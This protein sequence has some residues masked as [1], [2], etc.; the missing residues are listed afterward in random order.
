MA[1][2]GFRVK[3]DDLLSVARQVQ[4]LIDD[5]AGTYG[6]MTGNR[7]DFDSDTNG[8]HLKA[9]FTSVFDSVPGGY[10]EA[11][12]LELRGIQAKYDAI[13][14]Q[15]DRLQAACRSTA[16]QYGA[17]DKY[18]QQSVNAVDPGPGPGP[19]PTEYNG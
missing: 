14:E 11:Y 12:D 15:L 2:K 1:T 13:Q 9:A 10:F 3:P 4:N 7:K 8:E 19:A 5:I 17:S 18:T 6:N 16:Q